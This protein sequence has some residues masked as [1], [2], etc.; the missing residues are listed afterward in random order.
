MP[1]E[2]ITSTASAIKTYAT[3]DTQRRGTRPEDELRAAN[4]KNTQREEVQLSEQARQLAKQSVVEETKRSNP[5]Q[6]TDAARAPRGAA[7]TAIAA[8]QK[9]ATQG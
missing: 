5:A 4:K 6:E 2:S 1:I 3:E 9:A 7:A 8:Y